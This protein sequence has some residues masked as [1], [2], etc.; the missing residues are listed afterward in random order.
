MSELSPISTNRDSGAETPQKPD[1]RM[2]TL[3][4]G[5]R[6]RSA[7]ERLKLTQHDVAEQLKL[8]KRT[9][10]AIELDDYASL[11]NRTF[12]RGYLHSYARLVKVSADEITAA[13][14]QVTN[15]ADERA[16]LIVANLKNEPLFEGTAFSIIN[17]IIVGV[18]VLLLIVA[19]MWAG[20]RWLNTRHQDSPATPSTIEPANTEVE[21]RSLA[22]DMMANVN[23]H[24]ESV[25]TS[26]ESNPLNSAS[27]D[28]ATEINQPTTPHVDVN[29]QPLMPASIEPNAAAAVPEAN[30]IKAMQPLS[31]PI[32]PGVPV[33]NASA[34][35]ANGISTISMSFPGFCWVQ[36]KDADGA[37]L[38][39]GTKTTG[40]VLNVQGKAPFAVR[41][42]NPSAASLS[43]NGQ[44][45]DLSSYPAKKQI[46]L[47]CADNQCQQI[48]R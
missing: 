15:R 19:A 38:E 17:S 28:S 10:I 30:D 4:P 14:D 48:S 16:S 3:L 33:A 22:S 47:L 7:R 45:V 5:Q 29:M 8:P 11:P 9:I 1:G 34:A 25:T 40:S 39:E 37:I 13:Y 42:G 31:Q 20:E 46:R 18:L 35:P 24:N 43:F 26:I 32:V 23:V 6:L 12:A 44:T 2:L 27:A 41:L 36:I 21:P